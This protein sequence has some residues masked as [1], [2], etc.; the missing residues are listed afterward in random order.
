MKYSI[1]VSPLDGNES[2]Q[3]I[4][5]DGSVSFI[6]KDLGNTDYQ[7]YLAEQSTPIDTEDE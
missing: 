5:D 3:R 7:A 6:P 1:Y 4:N 2:I